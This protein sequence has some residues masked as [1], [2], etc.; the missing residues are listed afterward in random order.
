MLSS[1]PIPSAQILPIA[2]FSPPKRATQ[3]ITISIPPSTRPTVLT[4][5]CVELCGIQASADV[6]AV[7]EN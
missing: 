1:R 7:L 2:A 4:V 5:E 6:D 3:K